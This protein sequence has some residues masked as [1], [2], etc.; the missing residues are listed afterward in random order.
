MNF[1]KWLPMLLALCLLL[2]VPAALAEE[3]PEVAAEAVE[4][5]VEEG[6]VELEEAEL[7]EEEIEEPEEIEEIEVDLAL[8]ASEDPDICTHP[9]AENCEGT[10]ND[11]EGAEPRETYVYTYVDAGH[12]TITGNYY[13]WKYCPDCYTEFDVVNHG[14]K[15]WEEGHWFYDDENRICEGCKTEIVCEHENC[16]EEK[17]MYRYW[18]DESNYTFK[19]VDNALHEI[20]GDY[21]T[22]KYCEDCYEEFDV[23]NLGPRTWTE[24]HWYDENGVCELCGH[25]ND[26]KHPNA[27]KESGMG[28]GEDDNY[29]IKSVDNKYHQI[30]GYKYTWKWCPD[31][32]RSFDYK[33]A[34]SKSTW[35]EN[36]WYD[37]NGVCELCSH[38]NTCKHTKAKDYKSEG[39]YNSDDI[40]SFTPID[41]CVHE[42]YG[43]Y[44]SW[45]W[46]PSCYQT[47]DVQ[48]LEEGKKWEEG[49]YYNNKGVCEFCGYKVE[50]TF[51]LIKSA[52]HTVNMGEVF[53]INLGDKVA[54]KFASS[55]TSVAYVNQGGV[56]ETYNAGTATITVTLTN[57]KT[58][59]LT[60]KVVDPTKPTKITLAPSSA[61]VEPVVK[62]GQLTWY[63]QD[64]D[65]TL[66]PTI[67]PE[68]ADKD[69]TWKSSNSKIVAVDKYT[70]ALTFKKTGTVTI[71][72]TTVR[73][74]KTA[75]IKIK[76]V[77]GSKTT[78]IKI[79]S[80]FEDNLKIWLPEG[81]EPKT[82]GVLTTEATIPRPVDTEHPTL[83][84]T[85]TWK[86][87]DSKII[88]VNKTTGEVTVKKTGTVTITAT[89]SNKKTAKIKLKAINRHS[90]TGVS[91][92]HEVGGTSIGVN[93]VAHPTYDLT[94]LVEAPDTPVT[95]LKWTTSDKNI[96]TV[97]AGENNTAVVTFK[98]KGKVKIAVTTK[99][100][101]KATLTINVYKE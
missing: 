91:I 13:T 29:K 101:K 81:E 3:E 28:W 58:L 93:M 83:D 69:V 24:S 36:H 37:E 98:K 99:N 17:G 42:C 96:A 54:K 87:S 68:T 85:V 61:I 6:V 73:A 12:H 9:N 84:P 4:A 94:A 52:K 11:W 19:S 90:P 77:D 95:T 64:T 48:V 71:T 26:C 5:I 100:N 56:V 49:H 97:K 15:T 72:A 65:L 82:V 22:W 67:L 50:K 51:D 35:K 44:S 2:A 34:S 30:T 33:R 46:C 39:W 63:M 60:L 10:Y 32:E 23:E 38:K 79:I 14:Q 8:A 21:Y 76:V 80:P 53:K 59:T 41:E 45:K 18:D 16:Y 78:A 47:V 1:R 89:T 25:V 88:A 55:K 92:S 40:K 74:K 57:K 31:C 62:K 75:S 86:S 20:T 7:P 70:G 27:Q 43:T 66:V